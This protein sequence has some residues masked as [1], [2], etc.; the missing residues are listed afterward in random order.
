MLHNCAF[1]EKEYANHK[2]SSNLGMSF[3][4]WVK[5]YSYIKK[6]DLKFIE[7]CYK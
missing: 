4:D 3:I 5:S 7:E 2:V 6:A 1:L